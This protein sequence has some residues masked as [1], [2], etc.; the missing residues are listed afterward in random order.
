MSPSL[1]RRQFTHTCASVMAGT[2]L[3]PSIAPA[4]EPIARN[5][6]A[7]FKFSLAAYSYRDLF[8]GESP[9]ATL[10][11]FVAD[12]AKMGLE[13]TELTSYYFPKNLTSE[14][15]LNVKKRCFELGLDISGTAV[16]N[17]F[18][19]PASEKRQEQI[20]LVKRWVERRLTAMRLT[21]A[22][23]AHWERNWRNAAG[24]G[25]PARA[26]WMEKHRCEERRCKCRPSD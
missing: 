16:G 18:G 2:C 7:K 11:D 17:D 5:G 8:K 19:W 9:R 6:K 1:D 14:Y 15:L 21:A 22:E 26:A 20:A 10:L 25:V 12:C 4:I 24:R 3:L 13:G 23:K